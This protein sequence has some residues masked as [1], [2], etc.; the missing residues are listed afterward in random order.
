MNRIGEVAQKDALERG[1]T[2]RHLA[3]IGSMLAAGAIPLFTEASFAQSSR[4]NGTGR[5]TPPDAVRIDL[6]EYPE[7]PCP[8]AVE[9]IAAIARLA[10]DTGHTVSSRI[11]WPRPR[12][13][14]ASSQITS[15]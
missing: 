7:G 8:E 1:Y 13:P 6:N 9:A 11:C 12:K 3:R 14:R 4:G 5:V 15:V 2:R 10:I